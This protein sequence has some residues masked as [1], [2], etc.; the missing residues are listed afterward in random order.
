[1]RPINWP[2][3]ASLAAVLGVIRE[4][5]M[6]HLLKISLFVLVLVFSALSFSDN[7]KLV[8]DLGMDESA[9]ETIYSLAPTVKLF[10]P[11]EE[12]GMNHT[13]T[14]RLSSI[15]LDLHKGKEEFYIWRI[16]ITGPEW[17]FHHPKLFVGAP[18]SELDKYMGVPS[19]DIDFNG[20]MTH[21][22]YRPYLYDS[23]VRISVKN[24]KVVKIFAAEDWT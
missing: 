21:Y 10:P 20:G 5:I 6:K 9:L 13:K 12:F 19:T 14:V 3:L 16:E 17:A 1:M 18:E 7:G 8:L 4:I 23:W 15:T 2:R 24:G 11:D 22:F